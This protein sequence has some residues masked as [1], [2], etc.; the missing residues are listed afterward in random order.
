M[1]FNYSS[2]SFYVQKFHIIEVIICVK[3]SVN[4]KM[5][6]STWFSFKLNSTT[7]KNM[8][9]YIYKI[10]VNFITSQKISVFTVFVQDYDLYC[11][12][13]NFHFLDKIAHLYKKKIPLSLSHFLTPLSSFSPSLSLSSSLFHVFSLSLS[14][15]FIIIIFF[16]FFSFPFS[17]SFLFPDFLK[18][19]QV[20]FKGK[21]S[22]F[23]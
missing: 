11:F 17:F 10:R 14:H 19:I 1:K 8:S 7:T 16:F 2:H 12:C 18:K 21:F 23:F 15:E 20:F 5:I 13:Q 9:L 6:R 3:C 4:R 22:R